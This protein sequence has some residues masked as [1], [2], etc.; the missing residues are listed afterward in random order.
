LEQARRAM[1]ELAQV[2]KQE[3]EGPKE[4]PRQLNLF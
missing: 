3:P 4:D 2:D 1:A